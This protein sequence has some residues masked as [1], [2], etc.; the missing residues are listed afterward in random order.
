L[1]GPALLIFRRVIEDL[2]FHKDLADRERAPF[3][4][5]HS[6]LAAAD[7]ALDHDFIVEASG[8]RYCRIELSRVAYDREADRRAL[9][10]RLDDD[11]PAQ[12]LAHVVS[13]HRCHHP[14][15]SR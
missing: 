14:I 9:L 3:Q 13:R 12:S 5:A 10:V 6:E 11:W 7:E 2:A 1:A 8:E 15:C 4:N